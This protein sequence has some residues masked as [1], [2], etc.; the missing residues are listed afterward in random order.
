MDG[1][2][3]LIVS[4]HTDIDGDSVAN[5]AAL[6]EYAK[7]MPEATIDRLDRLYPDYRIDVE[8]EQAKLVAADVIVLQYPLFWYA[9]PSILQRWM[10][11][12][13]QHGFSHGSTG[14][15]LAGKKLVISI[16]TGAPEEAYGP[17][18][19]VRLEDLYVPARGACALTGMELAGVEVAYGVSYTSRIDDTARNAIA[20]KGRAQADAVAELIKGL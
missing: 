3:V 11:E 14:R 2:K 20:D 17:E 16:T 7:V 19:G 18:A 4:G 9:M 12:V 13:F 1:N 5:K 15:A 8:A 10:E 6:E